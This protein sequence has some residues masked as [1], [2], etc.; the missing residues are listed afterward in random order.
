MKQLII[1][2]IITLVFAL[3]L[4]TI[5][6]SRRTISAAEKAEIETPLVEK[7]FA[8]ALPNNSMS[9]SQGVIILQARGYGRSEKK[10]IQN[11]QEVA[12]ETLLFTGCPGSVQERPLI[13]NKE[14][15]YQKHKRYLNSFFKKKTYERFTAEVH[16]TEP[17]SGKVVSL[18]I[19]INHQ[20]LRRELEQNNIISKFGI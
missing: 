8:H 9:L 6:C 10:A 16:T 11:A 19:T 5:N 20:A 12:Y 1:R 18:I 7:G 17:Y 15:S 14:K 2:N 13:P 4:L 3:S